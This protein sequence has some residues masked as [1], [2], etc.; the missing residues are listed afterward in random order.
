MARA[1]AGVMARVVAGE[2]DAW[3]GARRRAPLG[4][5]V[6]AH[7]QQQQRRAARQ[8]R[9]VG[10]RR[11]ALEH[12]EPHSRQRRALLAAVDRL[13]SPAQMGEVFKVALLVPDGE[14]TPPGFDEITMNGEDII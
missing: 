8:Q 2:P 11:A 4:G 10:E 13:T 5:G 1:V 6:V 7:A 14:G 12:E 3:G 9:E